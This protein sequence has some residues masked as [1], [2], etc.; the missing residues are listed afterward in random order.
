MPI[1]A[2][3]TPGARA[4]NGNTIEATVA[5]ASVSVVKSA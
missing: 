4:G 5:A 1:G 3:G 2:E